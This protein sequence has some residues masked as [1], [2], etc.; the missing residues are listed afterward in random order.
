MYGYKQGS[1]MI[2]V[3][4]GKDH[5]HCSVA[6]PVAKGQGGVKGK[7]LRVCCCRGQATGISGLHCGSGTGIGQGTFER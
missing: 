5:S 6:E 4:I 2:R 7:E 3:A 1:D